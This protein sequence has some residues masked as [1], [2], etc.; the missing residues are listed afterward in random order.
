MKSLAGIW[1]I[2]KLNDHENISSLVPCSCKNCTLKIKE[3]MGRM[4]W[5]RSFKAIGWP[6]S[7]FGIFL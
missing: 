3:F 4:N 2:Y 1:D 5:G 6:K 7:L